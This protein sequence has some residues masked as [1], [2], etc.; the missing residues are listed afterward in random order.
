[1]MRIQLEQFSEK[2]FRLVHDEFEIET[3]EGAAL[4][5]A[6]SVTVFDQYAKQLPKRLSMGKIKQ[7]ADHAT[8]KR[9]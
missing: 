7:G 4:Y 3:A 6:L 5:K 9:L 1:M 2:L 8:E